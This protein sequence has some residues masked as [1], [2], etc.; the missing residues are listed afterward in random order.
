MKKTIIFYAVAAGI[1]CSAW[2]GNYSSN[3]EDYKAY[4]AY[5]AQ[6]D[7]EQDAIIK[8]SMAE[9]DGVNA[10]PQSEVVDSQPV[11]KIQPVIYSAVVGGASDNTEYATTDENSVKPNASS[12][13]GGYPAHSLAATPVNDG[14]LVY[15]DNCVGSVVAS[16]FVL[17]AGHCG[18]QTGKSVNI[19]A[20][21]GTIKTLRVTATIHHP[22]YDSLTARVYDVAIWQLDG[23]G[24]ST[25][26][27]SNSAPAVGSLFDGLSMKG[28]EFRSYR[29]RSTGPA[30]PR[31]SPDA[32]EGVYSPT[33][34]QTTGYSVPG[35]SGGA[36]VGSDG[37]LWGVVQGS[38]GQGDGSYIQSCQNLTNP[39]TTQWILE[40]I[41]AW[42]APSFVKGDGSI[43][44]KVQN[45]HAGA[46]FLNP[47][48]DG[49]AIEGNT[50]T[51]A[52]QPLGSCEL[53]VRGTGKV[54]LSPTEEIKVNEV[55]P[56][57]PDGN[58]GNGGDGGNGGGGGGSTSPIMLALMAAAA[59]LRRFGK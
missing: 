58:G 57:N 7:A 17:S 35:D 1:S 6:L 24:D 21:D 13:R 22:L 15:A 40:T 32:F 36:C 42:S 34:A 28:G 29:V 46:E 51:A 39:N 8:A 3:D 44:I 12:S 25:K 50:C 4:V 43:T 52:I 26:Y 45:L 47:V 20:A 23:K 18:D 19:K 55:I 48:A 56:P 59:L 5:K 2:A 37:L 41:N 10:A 9:L 49:V 11:K 27:I 14:A 30:D 54:V 53:I 38:A 16:K 31:F 33:D